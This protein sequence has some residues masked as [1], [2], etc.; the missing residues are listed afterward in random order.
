MINIKNKIKKL[1]SK[2]E[3]IIKKNDEFVT[4]TLSS[5]F[6]VFISLL[7]IIM[8][9]SL[10][11]TSY[12]YF[13]NKFAIENSI[14]MKKLT[15]KKIEN[16]I[17]KTK[18]YKEE[19]DNV[20][21]KLKAFNKKTIKKLEKTEQLSEKEKAQLEKELYL[22]DVNQQY[23][24]EKLENFFENEVSNEEE[25]IQT[26]KYKLDKAIVQ[27]NIAWKER[28]EIKKKN[29]E[30]IEKMYQFQD[31]QSELL[32]RLEFI[33]DTETQDVEKMLNKIDRTLGELGIKNRKTLG[34]KA[35]EANEG[36]GG[37]YYPVNDIEIDNSEENKMINNLSKK[38]KSV[39]DLQTVIKELPL[40]P[41]LKRMSISSKFG[42]RNDPFNEVKKGMHKG[43]DYRGKIGDPIYST[44]SGKVLK[45]RDRHGYGLS[46]EID[47]GLGFVGIFAHLNKI[48]VKEGDFVE[49]GDVIG[50]LGN[51]GR[52]TGPHLHYELKYKNRAFNPYRFTKAKTLEEM[53]TVN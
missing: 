52:S 4:Y 38:I 45:A 12:M 51:T 28:K 30:I 47:Y 44:G 36:K 17:I 20:V 2:K 6:Q 34:K 18:V 10:G 7:F 37:L 19:F 48:N 15:Q 21:K 3:F 14:E 29:E 32:E 27:R 53:T 40:G 41:P 22:I 23:L 26:S 42:V 11:M 16:T 33:T 25:I 31:V 35:K 8:T 49:V 9:A 43:I 24:S 13:S 5:K 46:V 1:F 39:E 50:E